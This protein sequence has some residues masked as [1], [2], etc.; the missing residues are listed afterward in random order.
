MPPAAVAAAPPTRHTCPGACALCDPCPRCKQ[1][2]LWHDSDTG[3][4][5]APGAIRR[6]WEKVAAFDLERD[7]AFAARRRALRRQGYR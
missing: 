6:A 2:G 4:C 5:Y 1:P 7:Q 3:E